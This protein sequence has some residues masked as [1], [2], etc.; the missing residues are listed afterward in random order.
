MPQNFNIVAK[1]TIQGP[2]NINA[3]VR[4]VQSQLN[5][6][7]ANVNLGI[8][9]QSLTN[10]RNANK[11]IGALTISMRDLRDATRL[12]KISVDALATSLNNLGKQ[13]APLQKAAQII[14]NVQTQTKQAAN[15]MEV[16]GE[17][18]A[19][20][21]RRF[22]AFAIPTAVFAAISVAFKQAIQNAIDFEVE[23]VKLSQVTGRSVT[24]LSDIS[25]EITRLSTKLGVSSKDISE[26]A[27]TLA[28]AGLSAKDTKVA[29]EALARSAL[30][31]TFDNVKDTTE[32]A[33]AAMAQFKLEASD[34]QGLIGSLNAVSAQFAVE[35]EDLVS[36]IRRSG[37]AF[38]SAGGNLNEL[39]GLFTSVRATTRE[40]AD[41]IATG[42]RTIFTRIQRPRTIQF[43]RELGVE[44]QDAKGQFIGPLESIRRLNAAL[45]EIQTTDPR[46]A[47]VIEELGGFRQVSKVIPLIQQ[48]PEAIKAINVAQQGQISI[49]EDSEIAQK[50][51]A[52]Q[53]T[54]LREEFF[55]LFRE[56]GGDKSFQEFV[57]TLIDISRNLIEVTKAIKPLIPLIGSIAL[58]Q[59][60]SKAAQFFSGFSRGLTTTNPRRRFARGGVVP[61]RGDTDSV[62]AALMPGE[63][64]IRKD[65]A[66]AIGY[67]RLA[68]MN[69]FAK[70][71]PVINLSKKQLEAYSFADDFDVKEVNEKGKNVRFQRKELFQKY[72]SEE[73]RKP[74]RFGLAALSNDSQVGTFDSFVSVKSKRNGAFGFP[75]SIE[76]AKLQPDSLSSDVENRMVKTLSALTSNI[77][78]ALARSI[79]GTAKEKD[80]GRVEKILKKANLD[81][82][83]GGIFEAALGVLGA[84]YEDKE[85]NNQA[86]DFPKGLGIDTSKLFGNPNLKNLP[87]DAKRTGKVSSFVSK[88][89]KTV[90][91]D[92]VD[93]IGFGIARPNRTKKEASSEL[94]TLPSIG[95]SIDYTKS[96][97]VDSSLKE[98]L[99]DINRKIT[100]DKQGSVSIGSYTTEI[101]KKLGLVKDTGNLTKKIR[102]DNSSLENYINSFFKANLDVDSRGQARLKRNSGGSIPG[103][104]NSDTVPA[105]LTPGEFV[106]N[107]S[108]ANAIGL[109]NLHKLNKYNS[110]GPVRHYRT[111]ARAAGGFSTAGSLFGGG[112]AGGTI[113]P[114]LLGQLGQLND[115][116]SALISKFSALAIGVSAFQFQIN[117]VTDDR[118]LRILSSLSERSGGTLQ[119]ATGI[120]ARNFQAISLAAGL[121]ATGLS[122]YGSYLK[123]QANELAS[124]AKTEKELQGA[125]S[126]DTSGSIF[127]GAGVGAG[128]GAAIG[129]V[130]APGIGT[131]IGAGVGALTGA[132]VGS[133]N[134]QT[135]ELRKVFEQARFDRTAEQLDEVITN[136]R[137]GRFANAQVGASKV[138]N[139]AEQQRLNIE[140]S[141]VK[142]VPELR[143]QL[144]NNLVNFRDAA[145]ELAK[146]ST[147]F[148]DF[149][150][151]FGGSGK[152]LTDAIVSI[153]GDFEQF[154]TEIEGTINAS[155]IAAKV[156]KQELES[157]N[158]IKE[159]TTSLSEFNRAITELTNTVQK[160]NDAFSFISGLSEGVPSIKIGSGN[161]IFSR[162]AS[163]KVTNTNEVKEALDRLIGGTLDDKSQ[164]SI[165]NN[166]LSVTKLTA[167]LPAILERVASKVGFGDSDT[168][169]LDLFK[170]ELNQV[171]GLDDKLKQ[172]ISLL[173]DSQLGSRQ[174]TGPAGLAQ[175]VREDVLALADKLV[176]E[177]ITAGVKELDS[178][179]KQLSETYTQI[180]DRIKTVIDAESKLAQSRA[181]II[182]REFEFSEQARPSNSLQTNFR[183]VQDIQNRRLTAITGNRNTTVSGATQGLISKNIELKLIEDKLQKAE[184]GSDNQKALINQFNDTA[185]A[186]GKLRSYLNEVAQSTLVL[187]KAQQELADATAQREER[188]GFIQNLLFAEGKE[189]R[190]FVNTAVLAQ[191][192]A[193][194]APGGFDAIRGKDAKAVFDFFGSLGKNPLFGTQRTGE[195]LQLELTRE[196][197]K[198]EAGPNADPR[199]VDAIIKQFIEESKAEQ[200]ARENLE[201]AQQEALA[202]QLGLIKVQEE[203]TKALKDFNVDLINKL[204]Q[205]LK[206]ALNRSAAA[207]LESQISINKNEKV[208]L[209]SERN[210]IA[211]L[212]D[213]KVGQAFGGNIPQAVANIQDVAEL[214]SNK[215]NENRIILERNEKLFSLRKQVPDLAKIN[216]FQESRTKGLGETKFSI[217]AYIGE[218]SLRKGK[219]PRLLNEKIDNEKVVKQLS[220][221]GYDNVKTYKDLLELSESVEA[222]LPFVKEVESKIRELEKAPSQELNENRQK[223]LEIE[224]KLKGVG[225]DTKR[226]E[227]LNFEEL[228]TFQNN[229]GNIS[230]EA[231]RNIGAIDA[232]T[233][234]INTLTNDIEAFNKELNGRRIPQDADGKAYGGFVGSK[235]GIS[236]PLVRFA[237]KGTDTIPTMLTKGEFVV[238]AKD[239][240]KNK[241]LLEQINA[242][243]MANGGP[244]RK[245]RAEILQERRQAYLAR[246][247]ALADTAQKKRDA[248]ANRLSN[249]Q[250]VIR[251]N[252]ES[253]LIGIANRAFGNDDPRENQKVLQKYKAYIQAGLSDDEIRAKEGGSIPNGPIEGK[254]LQQERL[255]NIKAQGIA[256]LKF[257]AGDSTSTVNANI[258]NKPF[259]YSI[260]EFDYLKKFGFSER[261]IG[262]LKNQAEIYD[263][264]RGG[265]EIS[266]K[267]EEIIKGSKEGKFLKFA[268]GGIVPGSGNRDTVPA[269]LTPGERVITK[270][271]NKQG[272]PVSLSS[273][274]ISVLSAFSNTVGSMSESMSMFTEGANK[275]SEAL[276][277]FLNTKIE[278]THS[279][280]TVSVNISGMEGLEQ[281]I[282]DKVMSA[283]NSTIASSKAKASEGRSPFFT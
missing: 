151:S 93:N 166:V 148:E 226:F 137:E 278:V 112:L 25:N 35:S 221:I 75:V 106:I 279:P 132:I 42:F 182:Q 210:K 87:T 123:T 171:A 23:M 219:E 79:G 55:A 26:V 228:K 213:S 261:Q 186:A 220:D 271:Q 115:S 156:R 150:K 38:Q 125:I 61:G 60:G 235:G 142:N 104:G 203:N 65:A 47:A 133:Y 63:F 8:N 233:T 262:L 231:R 152:K 196:L 114:I 39:L 89:L 70:G 57:K 33:I 72:A 54:K 164:E 145:T 236:S 140:N 188:V 183:Q 130:I 181:D 116:T 53:L 207:T 119:K 280:I 218:A 209:E 229:L 202:A 18:A 51:L 191:G 120:A 195:D 224:Q 44:L 165:S 263:L 14:K 32:G 162:A 28:Q 139:F 216:S 253:A 265:E 215:N 244:V 78:S 252:R 27:V 124:K 118:K 169:T 127:G 77:A 98:A 144:R 259:R 129:T 222:R 99:N 126:Q 201:K 256:N 234:K 273:E 187:N 88:N 97:V 31:A 83:I 84:P 81:S 270:Q 211:S 48:F 260:G 71:G 283:V 19:F 69:R 204:P 275:L 131:A 180:I 52:N 9:T 45:S 50:S 68:E 198:R 206:D 109:S 101:F 248:Y 282:Q 257:G 5:T 172:T 67:D 76:A 117:A 34:L 13:V 56:I 36:V 80:K 192:F 62:N 59:G 153:T 193:S 214:L 74:I 128:I 276:T 205:Q 17:E 264:Q 217:N 73:T 64:V 161:D 143:K 100:V 177:S 43:L 149:E 223:R 111:G 58:F 267:V 49:I 37:G 208:G 274:S 96:P 160:N 258:P 232:L 266:R 246:K 272:L 91:T 179:Y 146:N 227:G 178:S 92:I 247:Q 212:R 269:L 66:E 15:D 30:A 184:F 176:P 135:E 194:N 147:N 199:F 2:N 230:E 141:S 40:S 174:N 4:Q 245:T 243:Y 102:K 90:F 175:V 86:I 238:N 29:L 281:A 95:Q 190:N 255:A 189:K 22:A 242:G 241:D 136:F 134:T 237:P 7:K 21:L 12:T 138:A 121:A 11:S 6:L 239:A 155:K 16:F 113:L 225:L 107:K 197:L 268:T 20:A 251:S 41:S 200:T 240:A 85:S 110:G 277:G 10:L 167:N 105:L 46:F 157:A 94:K 82:A 1:L 108:A 185:V 154:K 24:A 3:V 122:E 249:K 173:F 158:K 254:R 170:A 168:G 103:V 163:G 159:Y 250:D